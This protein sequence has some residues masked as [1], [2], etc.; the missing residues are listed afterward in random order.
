METPKNRM[1]HC[2]W[3]NN[4]LIAF[5]IEFVLLPVK[6]ICS[7]REGGLLGPSA[8]HICIYTCTCICILC[9]CAFF[10]AVVRRVQKAEY[11]KI[12]D[13]KG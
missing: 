10:I 2:S 8:L 6:H 11:L 5:C 4:S 9:L 7:I 12:K 1:K 3:C 13:S